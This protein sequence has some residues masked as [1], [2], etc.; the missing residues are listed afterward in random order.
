MRKMKQQVV[1]VLIMCTVVS[2]TISAATNYVV[3]PGTPG[4]TPTANYTSWATAATNIQDAIDVVGSGGVVLVTNGTYVLTDMLT[5]A[6]SITVRSFNNGATDRDGTIID[7]NYPTTTNRCVYLNHA[8]AVLD[9]LTLTNGFG[10]TNSFS[11]KGGGLYLAGGTV[12]NC[13]I[14]GN[15]TLGAGGGVYLDQAGTIVDS[16]I[17][18]NFAT[19]NNASYAGGVYIYKAGLVTNCVVSGNRA[20]KGGGVYFNGLGG[21]G[22]LLIDSTVVNNEAFVY[23]SGQGQAGIGMYF[24]GLVTRCNIISNTITVFN[25]SGMHAGVGMSY[26]SIVRDSYIA[27]NTGASYGGGIQC[28]GGGSG[29]AIVTNC[30]IMHN[31]AWVGGGVYLGYRGLLVDCTIVSNSHAVFVQQG[32]A[33]NCLF[34]DNDSG[35]WVQSGATKSLWENCT[36][37]NNGGNGMRFSVPAI[38]DNCIVYGSGGANW[39][40]DGTGSGTVWTNSCTTPTLTGPNDTGNIT[41]DPLFANTATGNYRLRYRSPC[42]NTGMDRAWMTGAVDLDGEPRLVGTVDMGAYELPPPPGTCIIVR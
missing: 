27:Y 36:V 17:S 30:V 3:P 26:F 2:G 11:G 32:S 7:G 14:T 5:I 20:N 40:Y 8:S 4:V 37:V 28:A 42:V 22:G 10:A 34:A 6:D 13:L 15:E 31:S 21:A 35:I 41:S 12:T 18:E 29:G 16:T 38:V 23:T 33:R 24:K 39:S 1:I 9:G 19:N 25:G